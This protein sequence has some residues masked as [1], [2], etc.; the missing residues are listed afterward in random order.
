MALHL[1]YLKL[2]YTYCINSSTVLIELV[3]LDQQLY[4]IIKMC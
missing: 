4:K 1:L 3:E 2:Q